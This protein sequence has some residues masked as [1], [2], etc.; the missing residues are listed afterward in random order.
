[1]ITADH[2]IVVAEYMLGQ[3]AGGNTGDPAMTIAVPLDQYR[4]NY[5]FHAPIGWSA[6][7]VDIIAPDGAA[8][9]VDGQAVAGFTQ[10]PGTGF[11]YKH[12]KLSN[13]G[14][15]NHS[16]SSAQ[17]VG[18]SVYGVLNYGSY[19]YPGGLDLDLIPQ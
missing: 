14:D 13:N 8:V 6:N 16:V 7:Y 5:L 12:V 11:S 9:D 1:M 15:G 18:I 4:D 3:D 2:K 19:W 10:I 17:K